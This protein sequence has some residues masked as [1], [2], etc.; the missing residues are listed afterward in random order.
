MAPGDD[1]SF[2]AQDGQPY[3]IFPIG[4]NNFQTRAA[5]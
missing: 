4:G 5:A 1:A 3:Q 2:P